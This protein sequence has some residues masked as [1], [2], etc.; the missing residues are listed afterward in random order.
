VDDEGIHYAQFT[1]YNVGTGASSITDVYFA[2]GTLL[3]I[4]GIESSEGV[5]F[6]EG[7]SPGHLPGGAGCVPDPFPTVTQIFASLDSDSPTQ[8]NGV[9]EGSAPVDPQ[10]PNVEWLTVR[11][12]YYDPDGNG[13]NPPKTF[14]DLKVELDTGELRVGIHVQ[15]YDGGGS[16][17]FATNGDT[18]V[19][20]LNF[21]AGVRHGNVSVNW[22]TGTEIN[23]AGFNLYRSSSELGSRTRLN[24]ALIAARGDAVSGGSYSLIDA[25]GYGTFYYWLEDVEASGFATLHGP[26]KATLGPSIRP[27]VSRPAAP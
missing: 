23:N 1:F 2:D 22:T 20:L 4:A 7:A 13:P 10:D 24:S 5:S 18:A 14:A 19:D 6:S 9:N 3:G 16:E 8:P 15:G 11:F 21:S 26:V 17:S 12:T 25:P 27:P